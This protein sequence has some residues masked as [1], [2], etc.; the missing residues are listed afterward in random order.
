[1]RVAWKV[2]FLIVLPVLSAQAAAPE[3]VLVFRDSTGTYPVTALGDMYSVRNNGVTKLFTLSDAAG[4]P[5]RWH[6]TPTGITRWRSEWIVCDNSNRLLHFNVAGSFT[7]ATEI[8]VRAIGVAVSA[9]Q[10]IIHNLVAASRADQ[11]WSTKDGVNVS[12][13]P[14]PSTGAFQSPLDNLVIVAGD[15]RGEIYTAPIVGPPV[16]RVAWPADRQRVIAAAYSRTAF[17]AS[18]EEPLGFVDDVGPYSQPFRDLYVLS[19]G[20]IAALRNREDVQTAPGKR[21]TITGRRAD[22]YDASGKQTATAEF[23]VTMRWVTAVT[24]RSVTAITRNGDVVTVAWGKPKP[25]EI[26]R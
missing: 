16:I 21:A 15:E 8:A 6:S 18:L 5:F 2:L 19:D 14:L 20:G 7:G 24:P 11:L 25:G 9:D 12:R 3:F 13:I 17:R 23:P 22:R 26:L 4:R 10:L 1:M